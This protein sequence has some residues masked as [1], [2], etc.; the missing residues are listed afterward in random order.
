MDVTTFILTAAVFYIL[1]VA[2]GRNNEN[3]EE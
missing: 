3:F 1:G 2:V